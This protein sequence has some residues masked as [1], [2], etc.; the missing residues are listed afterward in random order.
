MTGAAIQGNFASARSASFAAG[1]GRT[2]GASQTR[3]CRL[4]PPLIYEKVPLT[5]PAPNLN[6]TETVPCS[7]GL[8][9]IDAQDEGEFGWV[10]VFE[11]DG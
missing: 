1:E 3:I 2:A 6:D 10:V 4:L 5:Q 9:R 11:L 7:A 8:S